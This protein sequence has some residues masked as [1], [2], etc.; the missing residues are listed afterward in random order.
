MAKKQTKKEV[1]KLLKLKESEEEKNRLLK[2]YRELNQI[3]EKGVDIEG[4]LKIRLESQARRLI[5]LSEE[6][7]KKFRVIAG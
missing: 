3:Y 2:E 7:H 6:I 1:K 5:N 4:K